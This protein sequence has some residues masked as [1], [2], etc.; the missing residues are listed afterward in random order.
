MAT[1]IKNGLVYDGSGDAPRRID[2]VIQERQIARIGNFPNARADEVIDASGAVVVPGFIDVATYADQYGTLFGDPFQASFIEEGITTIVGGNCGESLAPFSRHEIAFS[3]HWNGPAMN[4]D[5]DST[6][7]LFRAL[8]KVKLG[9]NFA[10]LVG[11][12]TIRR[13]VLGDSLR[14]LTDAEFAASLRMAEQALDEGALGISFDFEHTHARRV[15]LYE[16]TALAALAERKQKVFA[17]HLR[18]EGPHFEKGLADTIAIA[19][20]TGASVEVNH[21][22]PRTR[23]LNAY[24]KGREV[25]ENEAAGTHVYFDCAPFPWSTVP[26]S[27]FLPDWAEEGDP[28]DV[29]ERIAS[30]HLKKRIRAHLDRFDHGGIVVAAVPQPLS[31][32]AGKTVAEVAETFQTS[33]GEVL[34]KLMKISGL[35]AMCFHRVIDEE[36]LGVF[37]ASPASLISSGSPGVPDEL[38]EATLRAPFLQSIVQRTKTR[39]IPLEKIIKK[40]TSLPAQK[41]GIPRRGRIKEGYYADIAVLR[42]LRPVAVFVNGTAAFLKGDLLRCSAGIALPVRR[43]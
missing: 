9:V 32:F 15:P 18:Y 17:V 43:A 38:H 12:T 20:Q 26:I 11:Y 24:R 28:K 41:Y 40:I 39:D 3:A 34:L 14:D 10:T 7:R 19:E 13:A 22:A 35:K 4:R 8:K 23:S 29:L 25:F 1:L 6:S 21:F 36:E 30:P 33:P 31:R 16:V 37:L 42:D 2:V 27:S 5:W